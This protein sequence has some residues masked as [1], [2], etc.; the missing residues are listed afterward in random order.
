MTR[1]AGVVVTTEALLA[2]VVLLALIGCSMSALVTAAQTSAGIAGRVVDVTGAPLPGVTVIATEASGTARRVT[3][4]ND[5][6]YRI[7]VTP[8][9]AHRIDFELPHF[10]LLRH[11]NVVV[12]QGA[13]TA[14][15]ATLPVNARCECVTV[16]GPTFKERS[17]QVLDDTG[18]PLAGA[19]LELVPPSSQGWRAAALADAEGRFRVRVP[20][21]ASW[22]LTASESGFEPVTQPV[23]GAGTDIVV[24]RLAK[25]ATPAPPFS[26]HWNLTGCRCPGGYFV[27]PAS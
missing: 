13:T 20:A 24:F 12:P 10:N 3:T 17:G 25:A 1:R 7:D 23:S 18:R 2:C 14:I 22:P 9:R 15:D 8:G 21:D 27:P 4:G 26:E 16:I 19:R 6:R 11:H 5:G